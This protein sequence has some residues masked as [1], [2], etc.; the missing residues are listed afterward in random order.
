M[1]ILQGYL[2]E[3]CSSRL[4]LNTEECTAW[5]DPKKDV[6]KKSQDFT[7]IIQINPEML[8]LKIRS[9]LC[10]VYTIQYTLYSIQYTPRVHIV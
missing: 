9:G 4:D 1:T 6:E 10:T 2:Q 8:K 5:V 3:R 7:D